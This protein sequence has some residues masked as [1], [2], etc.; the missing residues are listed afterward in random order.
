MFFERLKESGD[1]RVDFPRLYTYE[2]F[3]KLT[4]T[5]LE[6]I[7][8]SPVMLYEPVSEDKRYALVCTIYFSVQSPNIS[9]QR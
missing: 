8:Q 3:E 7:L 9:A 6:E 2:A 5:D 1:S 4:R